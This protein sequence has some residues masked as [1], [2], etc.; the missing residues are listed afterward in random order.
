MGVR[1]MTKK[2]RIV[3]VLMA[4]LVLFVMAFSLFVIAA[5]AD[6]NCAGDDC[7]ICAVIAV[8]EN[9]VK[10]LTAVMVFVSLMVALAIARFRFE[11]EKQ[12]FVR[13]SNPVLLKVKL[14]N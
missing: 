10:G 5:E 4:A 9:T 14:T 8:C 6:H 12:R 2:H 7:P 3:A 13:F 1:A 11:R